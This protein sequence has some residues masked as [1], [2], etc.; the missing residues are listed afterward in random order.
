MPRNFVGFSSADH[1]GERGWAKKVTTLTLKNPV[2]DE[3]CAFMT[4]FISLKF[5][6]VQSTRATMKQPCSQNTAVGS[7]WWLQ[8][9]AL[10]LSCA[11]MHSLCLQEVHGTVSRVPM[12]TR[13]VVRSTE[14]RSTST[15]HGESLKAG[16]HTNR[17]L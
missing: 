11:S 2:S 15:M 9:K 10:I 5:P 3:K 4:D 8:T 13:V 12:A 7:R 6:H 16:T 14:L 1:S 17:H